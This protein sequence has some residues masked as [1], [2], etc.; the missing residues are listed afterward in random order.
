MCGVEIYC[1][2]LDLFP[3]PPLGSFKYFIVQVF[4]WPHPPMDNSILVQKSLLDLQFGYEP[5]HD[6]IPRQGWLLSYDIQKEPDDS[7]QVTFYFVDELSNNF[8]IETAFFPSIIVECAEE[9]NSVEE[10][11]RKRYEGC[12]QNIEVVEKF[13]VKE[14]NH[15]N[16]PPREYL[17]IYFRT[18]S[19]LQQCTRSFREMVQG[20]MKNRYKNETYM[21]YFQE[22]CSENVADE[23]VQIH[24]YDIPYEVQVGDVFRVRCGSWYL[25]SY[26]GEKY[27]I[28]GDSSKIAYPDLRVFAFDIE[29]TKPPLKF[30]NAE[31]DQIMMI[32]IM[33]E[34]FGELITNRQIISEDIR[35]FEYHARDDMRCQFRMSNESTEEALLV[36]FLEVVLE[37][38][39]HIIA[40]YNGSFFDWPFIE[41]RLAKY[42]LDMF[43]SIQF[44]ESNEYYGCPFILHMD[45]Y[46][47]VKRDSYLPMNNQ[48][49][50]DVTRI[51]LGYF[52][53]EIDPEDMV[54]FASEDPQKLA[55]Y[56]VSDAVATYYL[57]MKFVHSH[58]FSVS[59]LIP[60]SPVQILCRGSGALCEAL[61]LAE[62][63]G[64]KILVPPKKRFETIQYYKGHIAENITYVGGHVESLKA[65]IYRADFQQEFNVDGELVD[66]VIENIDQI[67][68]KYTS[69]R[70]Y[71]KVRSQ[72][73]LD[74]MSCRG[75]T[76]GTG[77]IYHFD[78]GAM[79]PNIILTNKLQPTSMVNDDICVRC[80][81]NS[82]KSVCR[83]RMEWVSRVEY[84]PPGAN[85][86]SMIKNQLENESFTSFEGDKVIKTS[87]VSMPLNRREEILKERVTEYSKKIY[88]RGKRTEENREDAYV[89]QREI[90]F[91]VET[92]KKFRDQRY[93]YKD[94]YKRAVQECERNPTHENKKNL[95]V[96]N[97]LQVA[98]K[99][100]LN[101][102]Y[103][104]VMREG[105]RWFSLEMAATVCNTGGEIIRLAKELIG[106]IGIPL[107][108]DTD[109][110]WAI[111][112]AGFPHSVELD[113][114]RVS[115]LNLALNYF[116]CKKF[117]NYQYQVPGEDGK[118]DVQPQNSIFFELDGPYKT[119]IIPA[120]TEE[121]KLLKKR[122]VVFDWDNN[123]IELKGFEL[124]RRG[125]LNFV[126][127]F[128]EDIFQHFNDGTTLQE[129]YRSLAGICN[130]WLDIIEQK[131]GPLD[132]ETIF[133]L[134]SESRNM[135]KNLKSYANR[136]SNLLSTVKRMS[137]FLGDDILEEKL[138]C[139]FVISRYP[140]GA[141]VVERAI[142]VMIFRSAEKS[143]YLKKWLKTENI[144]SLKDILDWSYYRKRF[145]CI[146]HRIIVI[147][148]YLQ[149]IGNP[150]PRVE[151]PPWVKA[152]SKKEK[153][154]FTAV[155]DIEDVV[156]KRSLAEIF[157]T[158]SMQND[159]HAVA[160]EAAVE[161]V[162][163]TAPAAVTDEP[164][165][166]RSA[167]FSSYVSHN[168]Q[169]WLEFYNDRISYA[170]AVIKVS[171]DTPG[172]VN[173][174]YLD[175]RSEVLDSIS[176]LY[177]DV[178]NK[179][180]FAGNQSVSMYLPDQNLTKD[181]IKMDVK[182]TDVSTEVYMKFMNHFSISKVYTPYD[183]RYQL[184]GVREFD[185]GSVSCIAVSSFNY[186]KRPI[187]VVSVPE[188]FVISDIKYPGALKCSLKEFAATHL[189]DQKVVVSGHTD[190]N[191]PLII[192]GFADLHHMPVDIVP[193][194]FL[195]SFEKLIRI[196][197][198]FN[199][200]LIR[201][202][203]GLHQ[204]SKYAKIP[205]L[206]IDEDVLDLMLVR[207][208]LE[209]NIMPVHSVDYSPSIVRDE[210]HKSGY[211]S[212]YCVQFEA[213]N[214][215]ILSIL[216]HNVTTADTS[217]YYG[218][219]RKDFEALR[220]FIK[221]LVITSLRGNTGTKALLSKIPYWIKKGSKVISGDLRD[222][223]EATYQRYNICLI[224]GLK[225]CSIKV[226][227]ASKNLIIIDTEKSTLDG[228]NLFIAYLKKKVAS[229]S[230]YE[231]LNLRPVKIFEK[232][233]LVDQANYVCLENNGE[234]GGLSE[235]NFPL[236]FLKSYFSDADIKN[237]EMYGLVKS[238]DKKTLN[239]MLRLLSYQ[240]DT[241][242]LA[243][244]CYRLM[245]CSE[246]EEI[247]NSEF[248]LNVFCRRCGFENFLRRRCLKCY[249][250]IGKAVMEE[251]AMEYLKYCWRMRIFGDRYCGKC[252]SSEER[253]LK[254]YCN[255]GGRFS[256]KM[257]KD[258]ILKLQKFIVSKSFDLEVEKFNSFFE[259]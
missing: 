114:K 115:V 137:E 61:L 220:A 218:Y 216:E 78:V 58:I 189:R 80:D 232:L 44:K 4:H 238:V 57:Y 249:D 207:R 13:N 76:L 79:Y 68:E 182:A 12:I 157:Y 222:I 221:D 73:I 185:S 9:T 170:T 5:Y 143:H 196:H 54:R 251:T 96:Y 98:Y 214:S 147:P 208:L 159:G 28:V 102:F 40:T 211:Y 228:C 17:K 192:E 210:M 191:T 6:F 116:V 234:I 219:K 100:V 178:P 33:T 10:Y 175:G 237:E 246:F 183:P 123:I 245:R 107:E 128:Q 144:A 22:K 235:C 27:D 93:V 69:A 257:Y 169:K 88:K 60:L 225:E 160:V 108:L 254:E 158:K 126:K 49:L 95:I 30:P 255:C 138:K 113:G 91:Y 133:Y 38:R 109:G 23:I 215:F 193:T 180:Y 233:G 53:D 163:P 84:I 227:T 42:G 15:L 119:M 202:F 24:E 90:P 131:G 31:F 243:S 229:I 206:N 209:G 177:L 165:Q 8:K 173:L 139:E 253:R 48:G 14:F 241:C 259:Q 120:S 66:L 11:L 32:S 226:V 153:L 164:P 217:L 62:S 179:S 187:F 92:V 154:G 186:Q 50:K 101:S 83:R 181:L 46:R 86:I 250:P 112:P 89:C 87:Y 148:A 142:P 105:S 118:F 70:D 132:E 34:D 106:K 127:K 103:G 82:D 26:D 230:G 195:E 146:L 39:P 141:P 152:V 190:P 67:L 19:G 213:V 140:Q 35:E 174:S 156:V 130:Y 18:E 81:H 176:S 63:V 43:T 65:G 21:D 117:T 248:N 37:H 168:I 256:R 198:E 36:R 171:F 150:V 236:Q 129:C 201:S 204:L 47:W 224:S 125:E 55:S 151:L 145:E 16:R 239:A 172:C 134:F 247:E 223:V 136:K 71:E 240:R 72:Y 2:G 20:S 184:F 104:Y 258:D 1:R 64:Y 231:L 110:I 111:L 75:R 149:Q 166:L 52:P 135:S 155:R 7:L 99:C 77:S 74:I 25:V 162:A 97:S 29:T 200:E 59:S 45:C 167:I 188:T 85:E 124:K 194:G 94:L 242:G 3:D 252:G 121:N 122:Y 197:S 212:T 56:S 203:T 199:L 205:L 161:P 51:K 41:K 244:N